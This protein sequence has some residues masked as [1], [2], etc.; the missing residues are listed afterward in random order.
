MGLVWTYARIT[1]NPKWRGLTWGMLPLHTSGICACTYHFFY[2]AP[3]LNAL[4]TVQAA[5]TCFGNATLALAAYRIYRASAETSIPQPASAP[6]TAPADSSLVGFEDLGDR[7]SADSNATFFGKVFLLSAL[8]S[9]GIKWGSL[10]FDA[11]FQ[12]STALASAFILV[13]TA[14][15]MLKWAVRSRTENEDFGG[16]L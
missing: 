7:L 2:N 15:N 11:P 13:P 16:F 9:A 3:P 4:V 6:A 8:A 14:L 10:G 5:L 1:D 12:H